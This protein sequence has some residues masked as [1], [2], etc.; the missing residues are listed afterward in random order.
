MFFTL[1]L[2]L[3]SHARRPLAS[4]D[5]A[6]RDLNVHGAGWL[7]HVG[8]GTGDDV[9]YPTQLIIEVLNEAPAPVIQ[10]NSFKNFT[11]RTKYWGSRSGIGDYSSGTYSALV[12]AYHQSWWCPSYTLT[13][14]YTPGQG[15]AQ[16]RKPTKCGVWRCDTFV[17]WSFYSGGFPQLMF[18]RV[19]LPLNVFMAF[20][21]ANNDASYAPTEEQVQTPLLVKEDASFFDLTPSQLNQLPYEDFAKIADIP[22]E[23]TTPSHFAKEWQFFSNDEVHPV[24]R[25]IFIDRLALSNEPNVVSN[26]IELFNKEKN[27]E[28]KSKLIQGLMLYYQN[29]WDSVKNSSDYE[30]LKAFYS[31]M[32]LS[33]TSNKTDKDKVL[34]GYI[35]FSSA[36]SLLNN[37]KAIDSILNDLEPHMNLGLKF[38]LALKSKTLEKMYIRSMINFLSKKN[39]A[40]FDAMFFGLSKLWLESLKNK[41]STFAIK[42]YLN[43]VANKYQGTE[44]KGLHSQ[45]A[46]RAYSDLMN[47]ISKI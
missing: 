14:Q 44:P 4:G 26:F 34:R 2:C 16:R 40:E 7:G 20:P 10:F 5:I 17:A 41:E 13:Q 25:G 32:M 22:L 30:V 23:E 15:D 21:Y 27:E 38:E 1:L 46:K 47:K 35:D 11:S 24:K 19:M 9:G 6:G 18:V 12:E 45:I 8:I 42:N 28:I 43:K 31:K 33:S 3:N 39:D 29:H 37:K 36:S